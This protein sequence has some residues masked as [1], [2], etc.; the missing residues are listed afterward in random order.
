MKVIISESQLNHL[1][2][3][4]YESVEGKE[5]VLFV[6]DSLSAG[7]GFTWNYLLEKK[8]PEWNVKHIVKGG[9]R[10]QWMLDELRNELKQNNYDIVFIWG[11]TNDM[12]SLVS[13]NSAIS[14]LQKMADLVKEQG[15]T[16]IIFAGYDVKSVMLDEKLKPTIYCD[17][18]CMLR[19]RD[20]MIEFQDKLESGIN[21]AKVIPRV[22]NSSI[23]AGDGTHVGGSSHKIMAD[24]VDSNMGTITPN[25]KNT[26]DNK[27]IGKRKKNKELGTFFNFILDLIDEPSDDT[28]SDEDDT[29]SPETTNEPTQKSSVKNVEL[30]G[31]DYESYALKKHGS[32]FVD[33]VKQIGNKVGLDPKLILATMYFESKMDPDAVNKLSQ[34]TG[35]I[36]FMP[37]TAKSLNTDVGTLRNMPAIQ[38]LDYVEKFYDLNRR[39]ISKIQSPEEAYF[40]VFY[41]GAIGKPDDFVLG[42]EVSQNRANLIQ[43]QNAPFD[44]NGDNQITKGEIKQFIRKKWG[45]A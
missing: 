25:I 32:A 33:R 38:Q 28:E 23:S 19:S 42:S 36:Q 40:L 2:N 31:V 9:V 43:R 6:G 11:G 24:H 29:T 44:S 10:T 37:F 14:N 12:F 21:G 35:L 20:R 5:N 15:G 34:A 8:H 27:K 45:L 39:F 4:L 18:P 3:T 17:K 41:P 26:S 16:P 22:I 13:I 30:Q 1:I 7:L